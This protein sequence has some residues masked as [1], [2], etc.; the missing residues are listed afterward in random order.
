MDRRPT[1]N[2]L[3]GGH[4]KIMSAEPAESYWQPQP[5]GLTA[6]DIQWAIDSPPAPILPPENEPEALIERIVD[7]TCERDVYRTLATLA[8]NELHDLKAQNARLR[9]ECQRLR[10]AA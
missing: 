2:P 3:G 5:E 9:D 8:I 10:K 7:L 1:R 4:R 6:I